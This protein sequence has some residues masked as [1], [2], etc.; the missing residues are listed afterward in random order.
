MM[1]IVI[2]IIIIIIIII[3]HCSKN[4]LRAINHLFYGLWSL[5]R[6]KIKILLG[7]V[8]V[9]ILRLE[10]NLFPTS[11]RPTDT[12]NLN[13]QVHLPDK[14]KYIS[15]YNLPRRHRAEVEA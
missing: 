8:W 10:T 11:F 9:A 13:L 1:M 15:P 2:I 5:S 7:T 12:A 14:K 6:V 4:R 3:T